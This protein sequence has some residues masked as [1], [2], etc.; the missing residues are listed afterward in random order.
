MSGRNI[1]SNI[2]ELRVRWCCA[3]CIAKMASLVV[4]GLS[5]FVPMI[6]HAYWNPLVSLSDILV[7]PFLIMAVYLYQ[8]DENTLVWLYEVY[9]G[10]GDL[11][12]FMLTLSYPMYLVHWPFILILLDEFEL[13]NDDSM[14]SMI[15]LSCIALAFTQFCR[16]VL[17]DPFQRFI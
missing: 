2:K 1:V 17:I 10:F 14:Q 8:F 7:A 12:D 15:G 3:T 11:F 6:N 4:D 9:A 5:M 16:I 13:F